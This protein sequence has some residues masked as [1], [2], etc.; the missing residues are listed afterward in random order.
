MKQGN[1]REGAS[2]TKVTEFL[3]I[4][5]SSTRPTQAGRTEVGKETV[6]V[7]G[8]ESTRGDV[9]LVNNNG[10]NELLVRVSEDFLSVD[11]SNESSKRCLGLKISK[12]ECLD[13]DLNFSWT[14]R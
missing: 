5:P 11:S 9:G 6:S 8:T 7:T 4:L 1:L 3:S 2:W 14:N 10:V 13:S 12:T